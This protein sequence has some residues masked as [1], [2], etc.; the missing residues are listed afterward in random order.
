M[1]EKTFE[2]SFMPSVEMLPGI[3]VVVYFVHESNE[4]VRDDLRINFEDSDDGLE[5][6]LNVKPAS[7]NPGSETTISVSTEPN[8]IVGFIAANHGVHPPKVH[9]SNRKPAQLN[10]FVLS[11]MKTEA[12][13]SFTTEETVIAEAVYNQGS[14]ANWIFEVYEADNDGYV[15]LMKTVPEEITSWSVSAVSISPEHGFR[16]SNFAQVTVAQDFFIEVNLP[17]TVRYGE[18]LKVD[19]L[20]FS[21]VLFQEEDF[22]VDVV[23]F[24]SEESADFEY[25][26]KFSGCSFSHDATEK[27]EEVICSPDSVKSVSFRIRPLKT[28]EIKLKFKASDKPSE[29]FH[30]VEKVLRVEHEGIAKYHRK[31]ML[32]DLR[33]QESF[34]LRFEFDYPEDAIWD[35][36]SIEGS[37]VGDLLGP[38]L[39]NATNLM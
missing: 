37:I 8:A 7:A 36:M 32:I 30:E 31:S 22:E 27:S 39:L 5:L 1:W 21:Y 38:S 4:I 16:F 23:L 28:G 34:S 20:I 13:E 17:N 29:N 3:N 6:K 18:I 33:Q 2:T 26:E 15:K 12:E 24:R 35:S 11:N 14:T 19:V 25:I 10:V 9:T